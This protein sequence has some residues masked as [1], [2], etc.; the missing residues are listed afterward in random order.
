MDAT[1]RAAFDADTNRYAKH[2]V[3]GLLATCLAVLVISYFVTAWWMFIIYLGVFGLNI[4]VYY[5][6]CLWREGQYTLD[7]LLTDNDGVI[8]DY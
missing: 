6:R 5:L 4:A 7:G 2:A 8:E 1:Q 3:I